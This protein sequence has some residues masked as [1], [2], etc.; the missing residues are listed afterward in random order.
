[1]HLE[2]SINFNELYSYSETPETALYEL[3]KIRVN[4]A[5]VDIEIDDVY[6]GKPPGVDD[7]SPTNGEPSSPVPIFPDVT[8]SAVCDD[9]VVGDGTAEKARFVF[10]F[11]NNDRWRGRSLTIE[12]EVS[13]VDNSTKNKFYRLGYRESHGASLN[14]EIVP[15]CVTHGSLYTFSGKFRLNQPELL[16]DPYIEIRAKKEGGGEKW[17]HLTDKGDFQLGADTGDADGWTKVEFG[18]TFTEEFASYNYYEFWLRTYSN[19]AHYSDL[20]RRH[21]YGE[22]DFDDLSFTRNHGPIRGLVV[23]K[24]IDGCWG[25]NT[26]VLITSHTTANKDQQVRVITAIESPNGADGDRVL[27][28]DRSILSAPSLATDPD[29]AVEVALLNRNIRFDVDAVDQ[30]TY[31]GNTVSD[32]PQGGHL[33]VMNTPNVNQQLSGVQFSR[34][35]Q[36]GKAWRHV[37]FLSS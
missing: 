19:T 34:F 37:S 23:P 28:L 26:D 25:P 7:F 18:V 14:F 29:S 15:G 27:V 21:L 11:Y 3:L 36:M 4:E 10:P 22:L 1:M 33:V 24:T 30:G 16:T 20:A 17:I 9:L 32:M 2:K 13:K 6:F 8:D 12:E 31:N 35:G 5:D